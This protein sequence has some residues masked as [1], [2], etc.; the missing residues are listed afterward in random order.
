MILKAFYQLKGT[1]QMKWADNLILLQN[2]GFRPCKAGPD[3]WMLCRGNYYE[4][5]SVMVD[6][7]IIFSAEPELKIESIIY[8]FN[9]D[10]K[11]VVESDNLLHPP[12][13]GPPPVLTPAPSIPPEPP[14]V[15]AVV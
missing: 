4:Y 7:L 3:L 14:P 6:D 9:Y 1:W 12:L 2:M 8:L 15:K 5:I 10:L 13:N 11:K